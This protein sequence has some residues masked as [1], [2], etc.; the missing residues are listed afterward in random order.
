MF[1]SFGCLCAVCQYDTRNQLCVI[2]QQFF[3]VDRV[4][5]KLGRNRNVCRTGRKHYRCPDHRLCRR[6]RCTR[7]KHFDR[8][9]SPQLEFHQ[10]IGE[11]VNSCG[12]G[13]AQRYLQYPWH[14]RSHFECRQRN[15][16]HLNRNSVN[17]CKCRYNTDLYTSGDTLPECN[18]PDIACNFQ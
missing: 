13:T 12:S 10:R 5:T 3:G 1:F 6:S 4:H 7:R 18:A 2:D 11:S 15:R 8:L 16:M 9:H 14:L 17:H